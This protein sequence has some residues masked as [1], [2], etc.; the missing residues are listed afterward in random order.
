MQIK[1]I[2]NFEPLSSRLRAFRVPSNALV[3]AVGLIVGVGFQGGVYAATYYVSQTGSDSSSGDS[4]Q[5]FQTLQHAANVVNAGDTVIVQNGT[6]SC[7]SCI[8]DNANLVNADRGGNSSA[9][10]TFQAQ[11]KWGAVLD[12]LN[13]TTGGAFEVGGNYIRIQGFEIKGFRDLGISNYH[14]GQFMDVVENQIH[15]IGRYCTDTTTGRDGIF[16]SQSN[17]IVEQNLIYNIGRY[18][19]GENGC[20]PTTRYYQNHDHGVYISGASDVTLKNNILYNNTHGWNVQIYGGSITNSLA[21]VNNTFAGPNTSRT[22]HIII[23]ASVA[24]MIVQ[25]NTF[26]QPTTAAID[27]DQSSFVS[28][29]VRIVNNLTTNKMVQA[30]GSAIDPSISGVVYSNNKENTDPKFVSASTANF[31]L[32][33]GSPAI[34]AGLTMS[35]IKNDFVGTARPQGAAYDVGA[36]EYVSGPPAPPPPPPPCS[37]SS[38]SR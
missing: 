28:G 36:Y 22:G 1:K 10:V 24:N 15:D 33:S 25:N 4:S 2:T 29:G 19:P 35:S 31:S 37:V 13:N 16:L 27:I 5:P 9:Y 14:G 34:D 21:I 7:A 30:N 26:Y 17:V 32:M 12:G 11:N 23:A 3:L 18:S 38:T 20:A 6:Y 8:G